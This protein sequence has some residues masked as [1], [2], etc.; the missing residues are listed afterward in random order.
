[1]IKFD[2]GYRKYC[3]RCR[4]LYVAARENQFPEVLSY[5]NVRRVTPIP[6][7]IFTVSLQ[8]KTCGEINHKTIENHSVDRSN[9]FAKVFGFKKGLCKS[10]FRIVIGCTKGCSPNIFCY[11]V[12]LT[13]IFTLNCNVIVCTK[14]T[15]LYFYNDIIY[16]C[17]TIYRTKGSSLNLYI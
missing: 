8:S 13:K 3:F 10:C 15:Y 14:E 4:T 5:V 16:T 2:R 7:I 12:R 1:M 6:C 9:L 11:I 17:T